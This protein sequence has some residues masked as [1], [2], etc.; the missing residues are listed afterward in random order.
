MY[1]AKGAGGGV[2]MYDPDRDLHTRDRLA[3][4]RQLRAGLE[5]D[6]LVVYFQPK[7]DPQLGRVLGVEA[8]VRWQHPTHGLLMP[9]DFL[10]LASR[11]G[12]MP[13]VTHH[14][15]GAAL[16]QLGRWRADGFDLTVAVNLAVT[17]LLDPTLPADVARLLARNDVP[18]TCLSLEVTEDGLIADPERAT[19]TLDAIARLGVRIS[20]D[21]FGTGWS[22][23]SHLRRLPVDELKIDRSFVGRMTADDEDAAIVRTTLDLARSLRLRV[24]AEGV[25]DDDTWMLL[26]DLGCDA[27]QG[28]VL[29]RPL[30]AA[31]LG[32]WLAARRDG[33]VARCQVPGQDLS[34]DAGT[35]ASRFR[36]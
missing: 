5:R 9:P 10:P 22:S 16:A 6:E 32:A 31:Q 30:P 26:A 13:K 15:L 36:M 21:D 29:S 2:A 4:G 20:L 14:V 8:L 7:V 17:D 35:P 25:E 28:Y 1:L 3:L 27:I 34:A 12:L 19:A 23:L 18:P 33:S 24:V 11:S